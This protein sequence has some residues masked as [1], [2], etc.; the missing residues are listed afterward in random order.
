MTDEAAIS[1]SDSNVSQK[2]KFYLIQPD[3]R[4]GGKGHG[5]EIA[6]EERLWAP[7]WVVMLP[8]DGTP[9]QYPETP[10]LVHVPNLGGMPRDLEGLG[11]TWIVSERARQVFES[12]DPEGFA[13][14]ACDFTLA[15]G[16]SGPQYYLCGVLRTLDALDE[17]ASKLKIIVGD[18]YLSGKVYSRNHVGGA[19][20]VFK[21]DVVGTGH[22][23]RT[24]FS[25]D[26]FCDRALHDA[27][28]D[29]G[30]TGVWLT[31]AADC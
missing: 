25:E 13:F 30:L 23:F 17:E 20:L 27:I 22:V 5:Q 9:G 26:A 2:G 1:A 6:N 12:V 29:V 18:D 14:A 11:G 19:N 21:A 3:I 16:S 31:D 15:D 8:P 7:G 10:H 28:R 24:P 4:G